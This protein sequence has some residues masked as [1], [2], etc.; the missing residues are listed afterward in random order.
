MTHNVVVDFSESFKSV[1]VFLFGTIGSVVLSNEVNELS[2]GI[3]DLG[4]EEG[5]SLRGIGVQVQDG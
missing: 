1:V 2:L 4:S 3:S 5:L